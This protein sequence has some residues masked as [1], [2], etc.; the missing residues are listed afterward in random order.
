MSPKHHEKISFL[1]TCGLLYEH[2]WT[3][4]STT[5][6]SQDPDVQVCESKSASMHDGHSVDC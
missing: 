5:P 2:E 6:S 3:E 1:R 4:W